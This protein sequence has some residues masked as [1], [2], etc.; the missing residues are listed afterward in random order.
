[1][2][3]THTYT[4]ARTRTRYTPSQKIAGPDLDA[5]GQ[6]A[7][8]KKG[9]GSKGK[10]GGGGGGR[11]GG[12]GGRGGGGGSGG[13]GGGGL[14]GDIGGGGQTLEEVYAAAERRKRG[15]TEWGDLKGGVKLDRAEG[16]SD[17]RSSSQQGASPGGERIVC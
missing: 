17:V 1:M 13:R 3:Y 16:A 2:T 15:L 9:G 5:T 8:P 4:H 10:G 11:G 6:E 12:G 14:Q 7:T